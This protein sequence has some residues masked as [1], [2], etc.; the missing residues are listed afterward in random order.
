MENKKT[1]L[2]DYLY[3]VVKWRKLIVTNFLVV[4][5]ISVIISLLLPKW[6]RAT[7]VIMPPQNDFSNLGLSTLVSKLP[8]S[9]LGIPL[10]SSEVQ[11]FMAI[12]K[13]RTIMEIVINRFDLTHVYKKKDIER[14]LKAFANNVDVT[15]GD[16]GQIILSVLDKSPERAAEM[17]STFLTSLDS[18]YTHLNVQKARNDRIF[19]E[20]RYNENKRDLR[21]AENNLKAFQEKYGVIDVPE[22]T[23]AAISNAAELQSQ[24]YVSEIQLGL[25]QKHLAPGHVELQRERE[26]L[27]ELRKKLSELRFGNLQSDKDGSD[28]EDLFIPFNQIPKLGLEYVRLLR[29]VEVQTKIFELLTQLYEQAKIEEAKDVPNIQVLDYPAVPLYK[30]KPKRA[31]IVIVAGLLSLIFSTVFVFSK[32][33]IQGLL[34]RRD[35]QGEKVLWIQQ[36][37]V[38]DLSRFRRR[39]KQ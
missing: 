8:F 7:A 2:I 6:Y 39:K 30:A 15:L 31:V 24:I 9:G 11:S 22:Q 3:V 25:K 12:L 21:T 17:A 28:S 1:N 38:R 5:I 14:T 36:Q 26:K 35:E 13:S 23:R 37:L 29:D 32:E 18:I 19:I 4:S 33:F 34:E 20:K 10:G 27:T 16:E